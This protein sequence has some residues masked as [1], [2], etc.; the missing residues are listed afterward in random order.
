[1]NLLPS[2]AFDRREDGNRDVP[3]NALKKRDS[4][5]FSPFFCY[6]AVMLK[7]YKYR[8]N[9]SKNQESLLEQTLSICCELY[10]AALEERRNAYRAAGISL[11]YRSQADQLP[12]IKLLREDVKSVHSQVLQDALKRLDRSFEAFF[13]RVK[14]GEKPGYPR[15]RARARYDSFTYPQSGF[16]IKKGK[17]H[18]SK[19][20]H[21][22]I[23][24]HRPIEGRIKTCTIRRTATGKWFAVFSVEV[25]P[26]PLP[27][28]AQAVGIDAG[29]TAFATLSNEEKISNPRFFRKEETEL[30]RVQRKLGAAPKR[31]KERT[32]RRKAAARVHERTANKRNDFAHQTSRE[33]VDKFGIICIEDL[34]ILNML[35]NHCL[36]K[37]ITDAAW[38]A[39][40]GCLLYKAAEAGRVLVKVTPAYTSQDCSRCGHRHSELRLSDRVYHCAN[41][42]LHIDRDLNA[43]LNILRLGLQSLGLT[44]H[45]SPALA[46]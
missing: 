39:F 1:M 8:I 3:S 44:T 36:A 45:R 26:K 12:E 22:K 25:E 38:S 33:I 4:F 41:C 21:I 46:C 34:M 19:I 5:A 15:F 17:L 32:K 16:E 42:S 37:S 7:A 14:S 40:F 13:R 35:K 27:Q 28:S 11:N 31:S 30:S 43:A 2:S 29:L 10:N 23:K 6:D 24:L 9:P 20:G 18:L